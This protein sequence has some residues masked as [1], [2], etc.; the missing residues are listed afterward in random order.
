MIWVAMAW[1]MQEPTAS[2]Q[3]NDESIIMP[4]VYCAPAG[5]SAE[6]EQ[7]GTEG[8]ADWSVLSY[9]A[10]SWKGVRELLARPPEKM[11]ALMVQEHHLR[12]D[13]MDEASAWCA[14][15]GWGAFLQPAKLLASGLT[16]G[17]TG[18]LVRLDVWGE[19]LR[20]E[21]EPGCRAGRSG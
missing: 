10:T 8:E 12:G 7:R 15:Q 2:S 11:F 1:A 9:N 20:R 13:K 3:G 5:R 6:L 17:G 4:G 19:G 16:S 14:R 21:S 18:V